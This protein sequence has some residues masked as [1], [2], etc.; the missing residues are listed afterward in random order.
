MARKATK[1][2]VEQD[3]SAL[4][5]YCIGMYEFAQSL[6]RAGFAEDEVMGIIVERGAYPGW[7]LPDPIEPER[8]G[9]YE[10]DDED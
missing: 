6:K 7:I 10:D 2:L 8:F 1:E 9:D 4:D 5:A 3:Y